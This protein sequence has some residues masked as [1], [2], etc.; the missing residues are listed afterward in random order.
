MLSCLQLPEDGGPL[1]VQ[2]MQT[3]LEQITLEQAKIL[4]EKRSD[5]TK[6]AKHKESV[7]SEL[8]KLRALNKA[9]RRLMVEIWQHLTALARVGTY[10]ACSL[11]VFH[12]Q[13]MYISFAFLSLY[14]VILVI[15]PPH[16][17][18]HPATHTLPFVLIR[19]SWRILPYLG[20]SN[21]A[22]E[23]LSACRINLGRKQDL[24]SSPHRSLLVGGIF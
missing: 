21:Q 10:I 8:E 19:N 12:L 14:V 18:T 20:K 15:P 7:L 9:H 1:T 23:D 3:R 13:H 16:T 22:P 17:H 5:N 11:Q 6:L 24:S 2:W 4:N